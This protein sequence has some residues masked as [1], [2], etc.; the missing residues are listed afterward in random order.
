V[1]AAAAKV[2]EVAASAAAVAAIPD[3]NPAVGT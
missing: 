2:G 1:K 3:A